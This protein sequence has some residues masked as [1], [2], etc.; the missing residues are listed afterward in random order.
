MTKSGLYYMQS[1]WK[2]LEGRLGVLGSASYGTADHPSF[3]PHGEANQKPHPGWVHN[4]VCRC[5]VQSP[6]TQHGSPPVL[7]WYSPRGVP[8]VSK[9]QTM[10][11]A[12]LV[13]WG[14]SEPSRNVSTSFPFEQ[15]SQASPGPQVP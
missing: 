6:D 9:P 7:L 8:D 1:L 13:G 15:A 2:N 10:S 3:Y 11:Q 14:P 12:G 4:D 5:W